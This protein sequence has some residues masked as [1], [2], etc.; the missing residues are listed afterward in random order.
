[1]LVPV[2]LFYAITFAN[3][4]IV[5][6][7]IIAGLY[8]ARLRQWMTKPVRSILTLTMLL[9]FVDWAIVVFEYSVIRKVPLDL[10]AGDFPYIFLGVGGVALT[11]GSLSYLIFCYYLQEMAT[12]RRLFRR[13][14]R[15]SWWAPEAKLQIC[16]DLTVVAPGECA[17]CLDTLANLPSTSACVPSSGSKALKNI[18][19]LRL[20]CEHTFHGYCAER[21][22]AREFNCP[23]CRQPIG[24]LGRCVR[25]CLRASRNQTTEALS[26][27]NARFHDISS[28]SICPE[29]DGCNVFS[30]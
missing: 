29:N 28:S 26:V 20:P 5:L 25:L 3:M 21:W 9:V 1:M 7:N 23:L 15:L 11:M 6:S 17:I 4:F 30:I 2:A 14:R 18:G 27:A 24:N 8:S 19:L 16:E 22:I 10:I 13:I 12:T